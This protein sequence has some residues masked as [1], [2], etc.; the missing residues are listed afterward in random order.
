M[1]NLYSAACDSKHV[2]NDLVNIIML[3]ISNIYCVCFPNGFQV[4]IPTVN[5]KKYILLSTVCV[6]RN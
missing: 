3:V 5:G 2:F 4:N 6:P 1:C